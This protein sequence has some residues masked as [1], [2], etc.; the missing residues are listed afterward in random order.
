MKKTEV[1]KE[2]PK[3]EKQVQRFYIHDQ[4]VEAENIDEAVEIWKSKEVK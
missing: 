2:E 4:V 1:K 3:I